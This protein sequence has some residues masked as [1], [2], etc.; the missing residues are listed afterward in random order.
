LYPGLVKPVG[1]MAAHLP[2]VRERVLARYP[3]LRS[4]AFERRMLFERGGKRRSSSPDVM[5]SRF[6]R[7]SIVPQP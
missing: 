7:T 5:M 2:T 6:E 4:S 3:F 1:L